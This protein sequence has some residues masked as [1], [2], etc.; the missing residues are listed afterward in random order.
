MAGGLGGRLPSAEG[1]IIAVLIHSFGAHRHSGER[2]A[3]GG[4]PQDGA[5]AAGGNITTPEAS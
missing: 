4:G 5:P 3:A 2:P 1:S